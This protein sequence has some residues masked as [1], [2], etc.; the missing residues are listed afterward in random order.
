MPPLFALMT[1]LGHVAQARTLAHFGVARSE[2]LRALDGGSLSRVRRGW[3]ATPCADS[4]QLRA[5]WLGGRIGCVSALRRWGV[6]SGS[7]DALH[8]QLAPN[9]SRLR[10]ADLGAAHADRPGVWHPFARQKLRQEQTLRLATAGEPALHWTALSDGASSYARSAGSARSPDWIVPPAVALAQALLCQNE[11]HALA[12]LDSA[13][14]THLLDP[15]AVHE[16][17]ARLPQRL[18]GLVEE[19]T[20]QAESGWETITIRR[21]RHGGYRVRPQVEIPGVGRYDALIEE[22]VG[23]EVNGLEFHSGGDEVLRDTGRVLG[24]QLWGLPTIALT[25]FHVQNDWPA[26]WQAIVRTVEKERALI[27]SRLPVAR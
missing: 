13:I 27:G 8:I 4:D 19:I 3:F 26:T 22:C 18:H 7:G 20:P 21:V 2:L 11:E 12:C 24:A 10:L 15:A 5:V 25:P 6:W 9:A 23:L 17:V 1:S 16:L 14:H